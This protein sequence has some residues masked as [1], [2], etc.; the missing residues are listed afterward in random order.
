MYWFLLNFLVDVVCCLHGVT[1]LSQSQFFEIEIFVENSSFTP[2]SSE[3]GRSLN[4]S[5]RGFIIE[6]RGAVYF[7]CIAHL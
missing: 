1:V 7:Q 2:V 3:L 6:G 5:D 4:P